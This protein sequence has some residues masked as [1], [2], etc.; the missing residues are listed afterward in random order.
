MIKFLPEIYPDET[1]YS[2]LSRCF[3][4]SGYIW[5]RGIAN[6]I[7]DKP[8]CTIDKCF[9]NVFTPEFKKLLDEKIGL[10]NLI[11]NHTL[12]K[13]YTRFL[14]L[15]KR[16]FAL[17]SAM[18][19]STFQ[20]RNLPIPQQS[21][22]SCLRYCP[23]CVEEDRLKYSEAYIHLVHTIPDI[24]TCTKHACNLVDLDLVKENTYRTSFVPL[25][26]AAK[27]KN[28]TFVNQEHINFRIAQYITE[29]FNEPLDMETELII[30]NYLSNKL[31]DKYISPRG[32][33]R[34]LEIL[35]EDMQVFYK[36]MHNFDTTKKDLAYIFRSLS[37]SPYNILLVALFQK[38]PPADLASYL[39]TST[40]RYE[41]F[42]QRVRSMFQKGLSMHKIA[43]TLNVNH[44]VVRQVLLGTYDKPKNCGSKY[45][46][47]RWNWEEID[48]NCCRDFYS[49]VSTIDKKKVSKPTVAR[50]FGLKDKTLRN[51]PKLTALIQEFKSNQKIG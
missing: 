4:R 1:F 29:V 11:L 44:E 31:D 38:I 43:Q 2:Y 18:N 39:G 19:N 3:V 37:H 27:K 5:N 33:Q 41:I 32:E 25:E 51:L 21:S 34:N 24:H 46:C 30:G 35:L 48:N 40:P 28:P 42:D 6:E 16:K 22:I 14:P 50:L 8:T 26:F 45:K 17:Q 47:Q 7:F 49:K 15:E 9:L 23:K 36:E 10:K 20:N 13:Y 12:F